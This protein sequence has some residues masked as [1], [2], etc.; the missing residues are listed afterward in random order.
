M[1]AA[2]NRQL[3]NRLS[4]L[5]KTN[6]SLGSQL[7]KISDTLK[8]HSP[9]QASDIVSY[10]FRD[11]FNSKEDNNQQCTLVTNNGLLLNIIYLNFKF[12]LNYYKKLLYKFIY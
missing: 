8:Q 4:K 5:T 11:I 2:E 10:S 9:V 1:V 12:Q 7:T 3:W 6:K